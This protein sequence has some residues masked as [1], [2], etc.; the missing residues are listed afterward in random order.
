MPAKKGTK[1]PAK[2]EGEAAGL[3]YAPKS[4]Y[5]SAGG[6]ANRRHWVVAILMQIGIRIRYM[7]ESWF[8]VQP[9]FHD[10]TEYPSPWRPKTCPK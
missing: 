10:L 3:S 1:S 5:S 9:L 4:A 8:G 7:F 6:S 2:G